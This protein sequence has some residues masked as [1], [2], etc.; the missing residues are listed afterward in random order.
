MHVLVCNSFHRKQKKKKRKLKVT[1]VLDLG[2]MNLA[3]VLRGPDRLYLTL[4][5][6]ARYAVSVEGDRDTLGNT[7]VS[8]VMVQSSSIYMIV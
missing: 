2:G 5:R 1:S 8:F 3:P 7:R 6:D 4:H